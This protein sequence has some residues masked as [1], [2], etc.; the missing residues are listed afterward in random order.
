MIPVI[1]G[2]TE[3]KRF[4]QPCYAQYYASV[5]KRLFVEGW[6]IPKNSLFV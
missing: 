5:H 2:L 3:V 1:N 4:S 6:C